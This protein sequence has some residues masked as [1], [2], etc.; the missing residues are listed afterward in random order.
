MIWTT[1][2]VLMLIS[3]VVEAD[4]CGIP[5]EAKQMQ[6][7]MDAAI[8]L[9]EENP[10]CSSKDAKRVL[11]LERSVAKLSR[12]CDK[13]ADYEAHKKCGVSPPS[14]SSSTMAPYFLLLATVFLLI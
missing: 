4:K 12:E 5:L 8:T 1:L 2:L 13:E 7:A 6:L 9:N 11:A 14:S 3:M 10:D